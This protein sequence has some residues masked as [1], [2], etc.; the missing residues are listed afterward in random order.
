MVYVYSIYL[1]I[2]ACVLLCG[3]R[4]MCTIFACVLICLLY[5]TLNH[6][7]D[8]GNQFAFG[9]GPGNGGPPPGPAGG[10]FFGASSS[11]EGYRFG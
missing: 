9:H 6:I 8:G 4:S 1:C 2:Y 5:S 7:A 10:G 3:Y 11:G